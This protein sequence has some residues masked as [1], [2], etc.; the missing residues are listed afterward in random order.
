MVYFIRSAREVMEFSRDL[1]WR[2]LEWNLSFSG[3][4]STRML[5]VSVCKL[6][7]LSHQRV[8]DQLIAKMIE[9]YRNLEL[10]YE[11]KMTQQYSAKQHNLLPTCLELAFPTDFDD[12][13][14]SIYICE[15][16]FFRDTLDHLERKGL[17]S[18]CNDWNVSSNIRATTRKARDYYQNNY[19]KFRVCCSTDY[20]SRDELK[21]KCVG[22]RCSSPDDHT[23]CPLLNRQFSIDR[24]GRHRTDPEC[25]SVYVAPPAEKY[26]HDHWAD[27]YCDCGYDYE[28]QSGESGYEY[29]YQDELYHDYEY[30]YDY[31]NIDNLYGA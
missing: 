15:F 19:D 10:A 24:E 9:L 8:S 30:I 23:V 20:P 14:C 1:D 27:P 7:S 6:I 16:A 4:Q 22:H 25:S 29:G 18:S 28:T 3:L 13:E 17:L 21:F 11:L 2:D 26:D 31:E 12:P 5:L